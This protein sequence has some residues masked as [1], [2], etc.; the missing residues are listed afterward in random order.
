MHSY[1]TSWPKFALNRT[2]SA[3]SFLAGK[4]TKKIWLCLR[5]WLELSAILFIALTTQAETKPSGQGKPEFFVAQGTLRQILAPGMPTISDKKRTGR[6][7]FLL[8]KKGGWTLL[9]QT[10]DDNFRRI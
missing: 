8:E 6:F 4:Y 7:D 5:N 1:Q 10:D 9:A 3:E 2:R